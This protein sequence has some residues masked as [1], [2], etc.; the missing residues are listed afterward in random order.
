MDLPDMS[1]F[2]IAGLM[3]LAYYILHQSTFTLIRSM[4]EQLKASD[5]ESLS[6]ITQAFERIS[7]RQ[8]DAEDRHYESL[9]ELAETMQLTVSAIGRLEGRIASMETALSNISAKKGSGRA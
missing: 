5:A 9:K 6:N 7:Q 8:K 3:F 2:G 1:S 4:V